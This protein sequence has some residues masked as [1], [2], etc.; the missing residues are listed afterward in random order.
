MVRTDTDLGLLRFLRAGVSATGVLNDDAVHAC[1]STA[2]LADG[3]ERDA[4]T[5]PAARLLV[6]ARH[7]AA[8]SL[9]S[10]AMVATEAYRRYRGEAAELRGFDPAALQSWAERTAFW[11]NLFN[12]LVIDAVITFGV[13]ESIRETPGFF[14]LAA[15]NVGGYRFSL[16]DIEQGLL[17]GN[18]SL[19]PRLPPPLSAADPR[20]TLRSGALDPRV[21]FALNC[22]ARSCPPIRVYDAAHLDRQLDAAA[23]SFINGEGV[24]I[25]GGR[26]VLSPIFAFY[27]ADFGG[28]A[29]VGDWVLCYLADPAARALVEQGA[30]VL[31][32]YD[33][34]LSR[35]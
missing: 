21:H 23:D 16:N 2:T 32:N 18:Q 6:A 17:R 19:H 3:S 14:H 24:Q 20:L 35:Q 31:G 26:A 13:R 4:L 11:I 1:R 9:P 15:Y 8:G 7:L 25:E 30:V 28:A 29:G 5:S 10:E 27:E 12:A 22:G 33:W 34:R